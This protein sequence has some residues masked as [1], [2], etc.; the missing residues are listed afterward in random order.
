MARRFQGG[1]E[2]AR[3]L[4]AWLAA[5][6][7]EIT[8]FSLYLIGDFD[9]LIGVMNHSWVNIPIS[10]LMEFIQGLIEGARPGK[11]ELTKSQSPN[12]ASL[13]PQHLLKQAEKPEE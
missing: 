6:F 12:K 8:S 10:Q 7:P 13:F 5:Q 4:L 9:R 2:L 3:V 1:Q 11:V